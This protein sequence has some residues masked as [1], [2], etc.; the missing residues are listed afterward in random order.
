MAFQEFGEELRQLRIEKALTVDDVARRIKIPGR[1]LQDFENGTQSTLH[2]VYCRGF[3]KAYAEF[4]G[5]DKAR[6]E[7]ALDELYPPEDEDYDSPVLVPP[8]RR[9]LLTPGRL[10]IVILLMFI[11]A[12]GWYVHT[13]GWPELSWL[14]NLTE[15]INSSDTPAEEAAPD[16]AQSQAQPGTPPNAAQTA[17]T[18]PDAA[19][20]APPGQAPYNAASITPAP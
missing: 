12:G 13:H 1:T 8:K 10:A 18:P 15:I 17:T 19:S 3:T 16:A 20:D 14:S 7:A 2:P 5:M 6:L 11:A 9:Q 4:L